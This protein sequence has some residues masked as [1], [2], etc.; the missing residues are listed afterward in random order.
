MIT[1]IRTFIFQT[2]F[3][4]SRPMTLGVRIIA[5]NSENKIC[6]VRH[7]YIA[8]W[9][10]PGGGVERGETIY[11]AAQK[12]LAEEVG[13][14]TEIKDMKLLSVHANQT[15]FKGDHVALFHCD[16]WKPVHGIGQIVNAH[17][18]A[19]WGFFGIDELPAE[20]TR[21]TRE[22]IEEFASGNGFRGAW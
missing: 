2:Y 19:E 13:L 3:R 21:A 8:G 22:R 12:E 5:T 9:H 1:K 17:E 10:L 4:F 15:N 7:T 11:E 6:L 16:K 18:I 20:T 14:V